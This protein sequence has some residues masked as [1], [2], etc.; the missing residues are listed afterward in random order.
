[1][2]KFNYLNS[3]IFVTSGVIVSLVILLSSAS[4]QKGVFAAEAGGKALLIALM[5]MIK[6]KRYVVIV[7]IT[8]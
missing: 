3:K 1:M 6:I 8:L 2:S 4:V 7:Q 5:T